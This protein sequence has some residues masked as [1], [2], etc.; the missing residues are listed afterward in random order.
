MKRQRSCEVLIRIILII[1]VRKFVTSSGWVP[2]I[3]ERTINQAIFKRLHLHLPVDSEERTI[4]Q[5]IF[6]R[7]HLHLPVDSV[8]G[9]TTSGETNGNSSANETRR[10]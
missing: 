5:A 2:G 1:R 8:I 10:K 7:L 9:I 4:N 3:Q 6:K